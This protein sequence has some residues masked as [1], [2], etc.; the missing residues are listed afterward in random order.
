MKKRYFQ[1]LIN[2]FPIILIIFRNAS[3]TVGLPCR[4]HRSLFLSFKKN[5][6]YI[7]PRRTRT[8]SNGGTLVAIAAVMP[9]AKLAN[10]VCSCNIHSSGAM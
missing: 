6:N 4:L 7:A 9:Y 8:R 10:F 2:N 3:M 5:F 1:Q